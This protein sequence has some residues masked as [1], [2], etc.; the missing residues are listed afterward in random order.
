MTV[1]K[2][3]LYRIC[4]DFRDAGGA[5]DFWESFQA[6]TL[7]PDAK[8]DFHNCELVHKDDVHDRNYKVTNFLVRNKDDGGRGR[9][10]KHSQVAS[11]VKIPLHK[12]GQVANK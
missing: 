1:A 11:K 3:P 8:D 6:M 2:T 12:P 4:F 5:I 10:I 9:P 7:Q